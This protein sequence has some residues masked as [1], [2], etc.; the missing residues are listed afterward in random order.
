M[1]ARR[2]SLAKKVVR[3]CYRIKRGDMVFVSTDG[4]ILDLAMAVGIECFRAGARPEILVTS[5]EY[6]SS[7]FKAASVET[8]SQTPGHI[9]AACD[10]LDVYM[11]LSAPS[12]PALLQDISSEKMKALVQANKPIQE[13][14]TTHKIKSG[15]L[16]LATPGLARLF[17]L[18]YEELDRK[19]MKALDTDYKKMLQSGQR[20]ARTLEESREV[21]VSSKSGTDLRF[22]VAERRWLIDDGV[23]S[24]EDVEKGD[25]ILNLPTGEVFTAPVEE[26]VNGVFV[27]DTPRFYKGLRI[28]GLEL[29][30]KN[31]KIADFK[32]VEGEDVFG[33]I[34]DANTGDK[35]RFAEFGIGINVDAELNAP[36]ILEEKVMGTIH[37]AIGDNKSFGGENDSTLHLDLI[38]VGPTVRVDGKPILIDGQLQV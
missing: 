2:K 38:S 35:D 26:S 31:G 10:A 13:K 7:S 32:A 11:S 6:A 28:A 4:N 24:D 1:E 23:I 27:M 30:F 17:N 25:T 8:L 16:M 21:K 29:R 37:V 14:M 12:D 9:L 5:S 15:G 22:T 19:I 3:D 33:E 36:L 34:L 20:L 18:T